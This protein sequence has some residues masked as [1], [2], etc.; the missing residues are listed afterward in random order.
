[1]FTLD[2]IKSSHSKV[3][4]GADFPKFVLEIK[5]LGVTAYETF[6]NNGNTNYLG[7]NDYKISSGAKYDELSI[8][9]ISN[10]EDFKNDLKAH[11]QGKTDYPTFCK[12]SA[13]SGVEKW[14][15]DTEKMTC[16]Y[17]DLAG[18]EMLVDVIPQ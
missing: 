9:E 2:Q 11:Q 3:K 4:S 12:D 13:K 1:M 14:I 17:Y 16:S 5:G 7:I 6:V 15:V 18:K 10:P 8:A